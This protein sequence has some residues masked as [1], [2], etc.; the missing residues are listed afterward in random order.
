LFTKS[1]AKNIFKATRERIGMCSF[2]TKTSKGSVEV[3]APK[4]K[5]IISYFLV[6]LIYM[7]W[8]LGLSLA[9]YLLDLE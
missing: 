3:V 1:L 2:D 7:L 6:I 8:Y 5:V 9:R 4:L